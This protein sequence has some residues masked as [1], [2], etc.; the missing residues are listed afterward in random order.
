MI[1]Q[2]LG[3]IFELLPFQYDAEV[4]DGDVLTVD[5]IAVIVG[6]FFWREV[7]DQLVTKQVEIDPLVISAAF[8]ATEYGTV[9]MAG[10]FEVVHGNGE[11]KGLDH[12]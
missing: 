11:V 2:A 3:K 5:L 12:D 4:G 8:G 7:S 9:K 1:V 6:F 10:G